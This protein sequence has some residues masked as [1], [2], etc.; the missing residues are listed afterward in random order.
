MKICITAILLLLTTVTNAQTA[1]CPFVMPVA[2]LPANPLPTD[3]IKVALAVSTP[4]LGNKISL[5]HTIVGSQIN[6][7]GCYFSGML[8][9]IQNYN[10]TITLGILP[11]GTYTILFTANQSNNANDCENVAD[12]KTVSDTFTVSQSPNK[13]K[14][15]AKKK[16]NFYPNP[17]KDI[18]YFENANHSSKTIELLDLDGKK[19]ASTTTTQN[20]ISMQNIAVGIYIALDVVSGERMMVEKR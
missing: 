12:Q 11:A 1:C 3:V 4:A 10:D 19:I 5:T 13:I 18:L 9:A 6:I 20:F 15:V 8:T 17:C 2:L 7:N 16:I 14:E